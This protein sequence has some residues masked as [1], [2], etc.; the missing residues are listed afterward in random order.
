[1]TEYNSEKDSEFCTNEHS[2]YML[3]SKN[4]FENMDL[5]WDGK[6]GYYVDGKIVIVTGND[7]TIFIDKEFLINFLNK[8]NLDIVWTILGEKQNM[9]GLIGKNHPGRSEFSYT[10]YI[11]EKSSLVKNHEVYNIRKPI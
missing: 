11:N 9:T 6:F 3:P 5:V 8:N 2:L 1:M 4:L 10:Y 7:T